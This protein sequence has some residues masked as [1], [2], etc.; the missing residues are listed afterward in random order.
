ML[1]EHVGK[2][3]AELWLYGNC[4]GIKTSH[5]FWLAMK[6]FCKSHDISLDNADDVQKLIKNDFATVQE[7]IKKP[8]RR[9]NNLGLGVAFSYLH[10]WNDAIRCLKGLVRTTGDSCLQHFATMGFELRCYDELLAELITYRSTQP[11]DSTGG[12]LP[13]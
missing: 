9:P 7:W 5:A 11:G 2:A 6:Y 3:S 1:G 8:R 12:I 10:L 4:N 13:Y